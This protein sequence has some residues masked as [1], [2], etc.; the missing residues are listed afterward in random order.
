M[1][2]EFSYPL[3]RPRRT[4]PSS[5]AVAPE[6]LER[7][8]SGSLPPFASLGSPLG[9]D[10]RGWAW[11]I[12]TFIVQGFRRSR[13][14]YGRDRQPGDTRRCGGVTIIIAIGSWAI[15]YCLVAPAKGVS[16]RA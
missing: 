3:V 10:R 11:I 1:A 14:P 5:G 7:C 2:S 8:R 6:A 16:M 4:P 9:E 15:P 13:K 12:A